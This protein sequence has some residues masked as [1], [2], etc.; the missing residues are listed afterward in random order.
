MAEGKE[1][2]TLGFD[3]CKGGMVA[4]WSTSQNAG[5]VAAFRNCLDPEGRFEDLFFYAGS[6]TVE[7]QAGADELGMEVEDLYPSFTVNNESYKLSALTKAAKTY[8]KLIG[9]GCVVHCLYLIAEDMAKVPKVACIIKHVRSAT[10]C[11]KGKKDVL[12]A[13]SRL[14]NKKSGEKSRML[15]LYQDTR[16]L[17]TFSWLIVSSKIGRRFVT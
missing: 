4:T 7:L 1:K 2:L 8:P 15:K 6:I 10:V 12:A 9:A 13:F 11:L 17:M 5:G 16:L 14:R 3:G